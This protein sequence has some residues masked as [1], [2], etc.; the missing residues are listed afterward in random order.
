MKEDGNTGSLQ[1]EFV[2]EA[3]LRGGVSTVYPVDR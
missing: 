1:I 2:I 3:A